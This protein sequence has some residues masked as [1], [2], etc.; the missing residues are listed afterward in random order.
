ME[1]LTAFFEWINQLFGV[2]GAHELIFHP[3]FVGICIALFIVGLWKGW[4][5]LYLPIAALIGGGIIFKYLY[6]ET[7]QDL[8]GLIKFLGA[9]GVLGL[10]IIYF[11]FIR[12]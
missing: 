6:P 12:D 7:S 2:E 10:V 1:T 5:A 11:G 8:A 4:K 9:S 3:V